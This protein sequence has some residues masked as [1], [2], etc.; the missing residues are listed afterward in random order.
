MTAAA[1]IESPDVKIPKRLLTQD[2]NDK[3]AGQKAAE[4]D[5]EQAHSNY[6]RTASRFEQYFSEHLS[7]EQTTAAGRLS[8]AIEIAMTAG[9]AKAPYDGVSITSVAYG[10][11]DGLQDYVLYAF[12]DI[13]R[14]KD[15]LAQVLTPYNLFH[16]LEDAARSLRLRLS[17]EWFVSDLPNSLPKSR[18]F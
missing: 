3:T 8:K 17:Q 15:A 5:V 7:G 4:D 10:P 11:R 9:S 2:P 1:K 16:I 13:R 6:V 12:D 18:G 14:C